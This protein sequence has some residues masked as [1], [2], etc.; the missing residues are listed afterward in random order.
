MD[1]LISE[2]TGIAF[3]GCGY[4]ADFYMATLPNHPEI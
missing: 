2:A 4:V 3:I 1:G